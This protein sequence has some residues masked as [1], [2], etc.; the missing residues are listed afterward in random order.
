M[1]ASKKDFKNID[2][3]ILDKDGVFVNFHKL[4]L[5]VIAYRAQLIAEMSADTS[6]M[7]V[8]VRTACIRA[9]GVDEDDEDIDPYGPCS[10]PISCV[11]L[12]LATSLFITK[13]ETDPN[14]K[15]Q[16]AFRI[17][18]AALKEAKVNLNTVELSEEIPGSLKKIQDLSESFKLGVYSSDS[19][20]NVK[21]TLKKFKI[22]KC[23]STIESGMA[24]N[25]ES[26]E[27]ICKKLKVKAENTLIITDSPVDI[28][29]ATAAGAKTVLVLSGIMPED[30]NLESLGIE[31]DMVIDSLA[32]FEFDSKKKV[33]A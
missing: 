1:S 4:W 8:K 13:N 25:K 20:N 21:E 32:D 33:A 17:I 30:T 14:Y 2:A 26:Y 24:K 27:E 22:E 6:E 12:A 15:W 29:A 11:R 28:K 10:M 5:R 23:I 31:P 16:E 19:E 18:D 3:I 7:L 9:M